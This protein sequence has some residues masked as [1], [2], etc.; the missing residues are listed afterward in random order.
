MKTIFFISAWRG[1]K[2]TT[3]WRGM[4]KYPFS[5][6]H[7]QHPYNFNDLGQESFGV[8]RP[9]SRLMRRSNSGGVMAGRDG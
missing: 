8:P 3:S 7:G 2:K 1:M 5:N 6:F 9:I 4:K